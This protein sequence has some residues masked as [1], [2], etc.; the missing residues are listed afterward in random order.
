MQCILVLRQLCWWMVGDIYIHTTNHATRFVP[1]S[2]TN[3]YVCTA[4]I[5][6]LS[7]E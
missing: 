3:G 4:H 6:T 2:V 1:S 5:L 7:N